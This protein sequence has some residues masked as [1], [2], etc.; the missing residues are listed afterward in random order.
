MN[1]I[2]IV[3]ETRYCS[4][5]NANSKN[6]F[7]TI[8]ASLERAWPWFGKS[9]LKLTRPAFMM[10]HFVVVVCAS[11]IIVVVALTSLSLLFSICVNGCVQF[12]CL[13]TKKKY[14][15]SFCRTHVGHTHTQQQ[16]QHW[17]ESCYR[18]CIYW[19]PWERTPLI[20]WIIIIWCLSHNT[21]GLTHACDGVHFVLQP[22]NW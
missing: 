16:H 14:T 1:M 7:M 5:R 9:V 18:F 22:K 8:A 4:L 17:Y 11:A 3:R 6:V 21:R 2:F 13:R 19:R 10:P 12:V 20:L 15:N